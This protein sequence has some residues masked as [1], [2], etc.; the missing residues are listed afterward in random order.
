MRY[1]EAD[2]IADL[3]AS[4]AGRPGEALYAE[5]AFLVR[6]LGNAREPAEKRCAPT[7]WPCS[8]PS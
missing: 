6:E 3:T 8:T 7:I 1:T 5:R 4:Y 2:A